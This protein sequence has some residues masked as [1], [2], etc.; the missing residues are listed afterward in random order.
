MQK[1]SESFERVSQEIEKASQEMPSARQAPPEQHARPDS[2][3]AHRAEQSVYSA[4][5]Q[6]PGQHA[7]PAGA[8][9]A[10]SSAAHTAGQLGQNGS[11]HSPLKSL[12]RSK[13]LAT[14]R[15][16][17]AHQDAN[18]DLSQP[19]RCAANGP[20]TLSMGEG[21]QLRARRQ[22]EQRQMPIGDRG[23]PQLLARGIS[24]SGSGGASHP[25]SVWPPGL[26]S[27]RSAAALQHSAARG[28][29][30]IQQRQPFADV[31]QQLLGRART[32]S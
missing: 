3:A 11:Q 26:A 6:P 32:A 30:H 10:A 9:H 25:A 21:S 4:L 7:G 14:Q 12:S 31:Q 13:F 15:T 29:E 1:A 17:K 23:H 20:F 22:E 19:A 5:Q 27:A 18:Q 16:T 8:K 24:K 2:A 28:T